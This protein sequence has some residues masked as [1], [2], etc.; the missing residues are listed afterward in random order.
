[1]GAS[2]P[3]GM[4]ARMWACPFCVPMPTYHRRP[5]KAQIRWPYM[6]CGHAN[7][8]RPH[9]PTR[10]GHALTQNGCPHSTTRPHKIGCPYMSTHTIIGRSHISTRLHVCPRDFGCA[11]V[12]TRHH[13]RPK[14]R[15][16]PHTSTLTHELF[17][18]PHKSTHL[19]EVFGRSSVI[20]GTQ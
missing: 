6:L 19:H 5:H 4:G 16:Q 3:L 11:S 2:R 12:P 8:G 20:V 1:M 18:R 10:F 9:I 17:G 14:S 15:G 13:P 7:R